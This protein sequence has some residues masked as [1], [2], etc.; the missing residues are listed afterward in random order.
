[1][2]NLARESD[3]EQ[4]VVDDVDRTV[5]SELER[6]GIPVEEVT[7]KG[8]VPYR[9]MGKLGDFTFIRAWYYWTVRGPVPLAVA[10]ELYEDRVGRTDIR[11]AGHCACPPPEPPWVT[12]VFGDGRQ[13]YKVKGTEEE[14]EAEEAQLD[15]YSPGWRKDILYAV[16]PAAIASKSFVEGY[17][18]DSELGLYIFVKALL[19]H[20][21]V[22]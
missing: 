21:V 5:V 6:C 11:V 16:D 1:M 17:H 20:G 18:I 22:E 12:H 9:H 8:E 3:C 7:G 14:Q 2:E 15:K 13:L 19:A 4:R 10:Q